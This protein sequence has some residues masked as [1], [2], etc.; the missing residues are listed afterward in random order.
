M[1]VE[2]SGSTVGSPVGPL[3]QVKKSLLQ[4]FYT[5]LSGVLKTDSCSE[6]T[7]CA[8]QLAR[9]LRSQMW[10]ESPPSP[11]WKLECGNEE[12]LVFKGHRENRTDDL[13]TT[14]SFR[15][16]RRKSFGSKR[17]GRVLTVLKK[18]RYD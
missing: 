12:M 5:N 13:K 3:I 15:D 11:F 2:G 4:T 6:D 8:R 1:V 14:T 18:A 16:D 17:G 9:G 10:S 7:E